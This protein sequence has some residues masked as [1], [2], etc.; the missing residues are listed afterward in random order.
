MEWIATSL[1]IV[2]KYGGLTGLVLVLWF[3][4]RYFANKTI[5]KINQTL[6]ST[7]VNNTAAL[8]SLIEVV[9]E[10]K[11]TSDKMV[12]AADKCELKNE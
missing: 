6:L 9:R 5:S 1:E 11:E 2:L 8:T 7:I 12:R 4:D 3:A 10:T